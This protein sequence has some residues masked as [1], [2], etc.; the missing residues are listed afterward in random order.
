MSI[1]PVLRA[2]ELIK[3]LLKAGFRII[4]QT[5]SHIRLSHPADSTRETSVPQHPG[6]LPRWLLSAIL[7]QARISVKELRKLLGKK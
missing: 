7:K 1:V 2:R 5:G 4:R 6:N 3:A